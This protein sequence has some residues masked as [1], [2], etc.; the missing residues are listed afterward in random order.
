MWD[1]AGQVSEW[2]APATFEMGLL[3]P[4]DWTARW[5]ENPS[6]QY[7]AAERLR[8]PAPGLREG[9]SGRR[10]RRPGRGCYVTGLG[11][12]AVTLNGHPV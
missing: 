12:Y 2:S 9:I 3:D 4:K 5:I 8:D 10:T 11:M 7:H 6:Y 1:T